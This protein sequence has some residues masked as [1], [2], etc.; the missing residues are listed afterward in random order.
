MQYARTGT[1]ELVPLRKPSVDTG[2]LLLKRV[3]LSVLVVIVIVMC[4]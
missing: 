1:G 3:C 4:D 2:S